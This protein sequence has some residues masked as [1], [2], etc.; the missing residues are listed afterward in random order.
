MAGIGAWRVHE[1]VELVMD[2][3]FYEMAGFVVYEVV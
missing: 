3:V 1:M 2:Q